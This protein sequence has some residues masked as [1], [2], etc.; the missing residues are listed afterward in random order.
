MK[1][2]VIIPCFH[3]EEFVGRAIESVKAQLFQD[4]ELLIVCESED[5]ASIEAV[6]KCGVEP[7]IGVFHSAGASRNAGLDRASGDYILFLDSDDWFMGPDCF[8]VLDQFTRLRP[9]ILT[10][11]FIFGEHGYTSALGNRGSMYPNVWSRAWRRAYLEKYHIRFPEKSWAEDVE[12]TQEA[13]AHQP[14]HRITDLPFVHYTYPR[15]GSLTA[16]KESDNG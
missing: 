3:S 1:F 4:Y 12:F 16:E 10:C 5:P 8:T 7:I 14:E 6:R 2:S 13:F 9:D 11:G 15:C